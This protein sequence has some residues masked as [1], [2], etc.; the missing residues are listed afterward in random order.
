VPWAGGEPEAVPPL[1]LAWVGFA[2]AAAALLGQGLMAL[3]PGEPDPVSDMPGFLTGL[4]G[5]GNGLVGIIGGYV[6]VLWCVHR[7]H[8]ILRA[9]TGGQYPISPRAAVGYHFVPLYNLFWM[10]KWTSELSM[11]LNMQGLVTVTVG[12]NLAG[13]LVLSSIAGNFVFG[14]AIGGW[15]GVMLYIEMKLRAH[16]AAISAQAGAAPPPAPMSGY[17]Q[18]P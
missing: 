2:F 14:V 9:L 13:A 3:A 7:F 1:P 18:T 8:R 6:W 15:T 4:F 11:Y 10:F 12:G 17:G 16:L 5:V